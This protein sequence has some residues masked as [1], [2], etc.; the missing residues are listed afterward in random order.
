MVDPYLISYL[1]EQD[2]PCPGCQYNLRGLQ[3]DHCPECGFGFNLGSLQS[4]KKKQ[5]SIKWCR[6]LWSEPRAA[7][8]PFV[9]IVVLLPLSGISSG[10]DRLPQCWLD[11]LCG[12]AFLF[13]ELVIWCAIVPFVVL[14]GCAVRLPDEA[15]VLVSIGRFSTRALWVLLVV[16]VLG[17]GVTLFAG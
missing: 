8:V 4:V 9:L 17:T 6:E 3:Q 1:A 13:G 11:A 2:I 7:W 14:A 12:D 5:C 15:G 10:A 16:N